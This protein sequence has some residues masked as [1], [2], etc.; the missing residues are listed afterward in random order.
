MNELHERVRE[1]RACETV[2]KRTD[3]EKKQREIESRQT[4]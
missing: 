1:N 3:E 2:K 4:E